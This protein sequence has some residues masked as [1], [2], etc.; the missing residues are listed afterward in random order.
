MLAR[1][2]LLLCPDW[3]SNRS[4]IHPNLTLQNYQSFRY[5]WH[6]RNPTRFICIQYSKYVCFGIA[7]AEKLFHIGRVFQL[8]LFQVYILFSFITTGL[9]QLVIIPFSS[10]YSCPG[11]PVWM[12]CWLKAVVANPVAI[13][14]GICWAI[15]FLLPNRMRPL[16][17]RL[18][19]ARLMAH[20]QLVLNL[21]AQL[22]ALHRMLEMF[23]QQLL[24]PAMAKRKRNLAVLKPSHRI[25]TFRILEVL[26]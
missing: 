19:L 21:Q 17:V 16:L 25:N 5:Q 12:I 11:I 14:I 22:T 7:G 9:C 15:S 6:D 8:F 24:L 10:I 2:I 1:G 13:P 18:P 4:L 23:R 26:M 20:L 3:W